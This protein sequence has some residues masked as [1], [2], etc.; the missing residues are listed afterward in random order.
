MNEY[1]HSLSSY[2]WMSNIMIP[3]LSVACGCNKA[4]HVPLLEQDI[5]ERQ[6]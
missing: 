6:A 1:A 4:R 3:I 5:R 2:E